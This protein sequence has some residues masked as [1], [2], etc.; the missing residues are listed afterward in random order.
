M[1]RLVELGGAPVN[2]AERDVVQR[3]VA[4]LPKRWA[5]IPNVDIHDQRSGHPYECDAIVVGGSGVWIVEVK[6]WRGRIQAVSGRQWQLNVHQ[7]KQR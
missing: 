6:G 7:L 5:V 1:A 2:R 3:L 4:D